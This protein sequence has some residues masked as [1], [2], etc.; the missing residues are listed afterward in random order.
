MLKIDAFDLLTRLNRQGTTVVA[1]M[2]DLNLAALY[3]RHLL[4]LKE[5]R[6]YA[7]G[8]TLE[9]FKRDVIEGVYATPVEVF[10]HPSTGR[11]HAVFLPRN[12]AGT[13]QPVE[14]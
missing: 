4:F 14:E 6:V 10:V 2:H 8:P 12:P 5:G 13:S 9:V 3:C 7:L 11:P 1:V